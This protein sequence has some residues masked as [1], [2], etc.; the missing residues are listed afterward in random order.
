MYKQEDIGQLLGSGVLFN[1][2]NS[3]PSKQDSSMI[4]G[5][6]TLRELT[7]RVKEEQQFISRID[8]KT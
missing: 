2:Y 4:L 3:S 5:L 6:W 7:S 1:F 8:K